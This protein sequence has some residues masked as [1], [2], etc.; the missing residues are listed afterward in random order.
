MAGGAGLRLAGDTERD[1]NRLVWTTFDAWA[2]WLADPVFSSADEGLFVGLDLNPM[3]P[4]RK[5]SVES[6]TLT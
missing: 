6:V 4:G 5:L 3:D 1:P 2:Y